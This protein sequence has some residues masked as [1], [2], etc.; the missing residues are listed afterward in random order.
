MK[1]IRTA[2]KR[3]GLTQRQFAREA[4]FSLTTLKRYMKAKQ[5]PM[6]RLAAVRNVAYVHSHT[7]RQIE[8]RNQRLRATAIRKESMAK[9]RQDYRPLK[10]V[11]L[12]GHASVV[13]GKQAGRIRAGYI[14]ANANRARLGL[15][16]I[17]PSGF[18]GNPEKLP[19]ILRHQNSRRFLESRRENGRKGFKAS[20]HTGLEYA[21]VHP[22]DIQDVMDAL[23]KMNS[24]QI[25][26]MYRFASNE[27]WF[28]LISPPAEGDKMPA[29]PD[30]SGVFAYLGLARHNLNIKL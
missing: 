14:Q 16:G 24:R 10:F 28:I 29:A 11:D 17:S 22:Q 6:G 3:S 9:A 5:V 2:W 25:D 18:Y 20:I 19:N 8:R 30:V 13:S 26:A 23:N 4:G 15:P 27:H 21:N 12:N 7:Q 1:S